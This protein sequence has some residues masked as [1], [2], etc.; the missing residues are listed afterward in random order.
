MIVN[1]I[2]NGVEAI[3]GKEGELD[4]FEV[5][6]EE[7]VEII[8]KDTGYGMPQEMVEKLMK[9]EEELGTTKEDGHGIGMQQIMGTIK[10]MKGKLRVEAKEGE[11]TEFIV[12]F[13]KVERPKWFR[14]KLEIKKGEELVIVDDEEEVHEVWKDKLKGY[15]K[16]IRVKNFRQ[17]VEALNYLNSLDNNEKEKVFLLC[18]YEF[19]KQD[20]RGVEI[21]EKSG[22]KERHLLVTNVYL[23]DI[24]DFDERSKYLKIFPK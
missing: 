18:E 9:W 23:S 19:R 20:I 13:Q 4:V 7:E 14:D 6:K 8:V 3:E 24:K 10:R 16:E 22:L 17:G 21:I 5:V 12:G 1:V 2:K 11:G 15:E